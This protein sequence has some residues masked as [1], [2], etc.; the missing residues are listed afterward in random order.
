MNLPSVTRVAAL[1]AA[2]A[3]STFTSPSAQAASGHPS[4]S[5]E[6]KADS[7]SGADS[8]G[9][10]SI[11]VAVKCGAK[12]GFDHQDLKGT[13]RVFGF[14]EDGYLQSRLSFTLRDDSLS[15]NPWDAGH[16][17]MSCDGTLMY[18]PD[19]QGFASFAKYG[20]EFICHSHTT[21][22]SSLYCGPW[23]LDTGSLMATKVSCRTL[24]QATMRTWTRYK[25]DGSLL[26]KVEA[27]T[28]G[29]VLIRVYDPKIK[30]VI[31]QPDSLKGNLKYVLPVVKGIARYVPKNNRMNF[32]RIVIGTYQY[33][34][35][36]DYVVSPYIFWGTRR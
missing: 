7:W 18:V 28:N 12:L 24:S 35:Y 23:S 3:F 11:D 21:T 1:I 34:G 33:D 8:T 32:G 30:K 26:A 22:H 10:L 9:Y 36:S 20:A 13:T 16:P 15:S 29:T 14:L 2:T 5:C 31:I 17:S 25:I 27:K 6:V 19:P 4:I